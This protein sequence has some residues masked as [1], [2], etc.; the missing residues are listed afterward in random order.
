M[1]PVAENVAAFEVW[2]WSEAKGKYGYH[3]DSTDNDGKLPLWVDLYLELFSEEEAIQMAIL[4]DANQ[5]TAQRYRD[6]HS[7]RYAARVYF[8]NRLGYT[9]L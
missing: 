1:E 6:Q 8:P 9:K 4:W 7:R 5:E 2:A 3:Y